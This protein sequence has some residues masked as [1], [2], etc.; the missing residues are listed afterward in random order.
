MAWKRFAGEIGSTAAR[1]RGQKNVGLKAGRIKKPPLSGW[2]AAAGS[3]LQSVSRMGQHP[4]TGT[5]RSE[6]TGGTPRTFRE[7]RAG[8]KGSDEIGQ[9][10]TDHE[11]GN[12]RH[13][14]RCILRRRSRKNVSR[15]P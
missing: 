11:H 9:I 3:S 6:T 8:S 1:I 13:E 7:H 14:A 10:E 15:R 12:Q 4:G 5:G 2:T